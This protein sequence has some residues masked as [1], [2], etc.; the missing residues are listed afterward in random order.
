MSDS[1]IDRT[2]RTVLIV[3]NSWRPLPGRAAL[4]QQR[5]NNFR[6]RPAPYDPNSVAD[7]SKYFCSFSNTSIWRYSEGTMRNSTIGLT[8]EYGP[9]GA[10]VAA[11]RDS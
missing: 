5:I 2:L 3:R 1:G 9:A 10:A 11:K 6:S 8:G 7:H 4:W